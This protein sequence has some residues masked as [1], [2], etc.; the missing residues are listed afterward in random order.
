MGG[1]WRPVR[2]LKLLQAA[3]ILFLLPIYTVKKIVVTLTTIPWL[4]FLTTLSS[5]LLDDNV[6]IHVHRKLE[7][8]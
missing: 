1:E 2:N 8:I 7:P 3:T 4:I 6:V 5:E